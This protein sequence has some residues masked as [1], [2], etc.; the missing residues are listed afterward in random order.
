M[1]DEF[2]PAAAR[3]LLEQSSGEWCPPDVFATFENFDANLAGIPVLAY[4]YDAETR[5]AGA[6]L[7]TDDR[8]TMEHA[9]NALQS[10]ANR[11]DVDCASGLLEKISVRIHPPDTHKK[12]D[13]SA[14]VF[15]RAHRCGFVIAE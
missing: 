9:S 5:A 11:R 6:A 8:A 3:S 2:G 10:G 1:T 4:P 15:A 13:G 14:M 12:R 7:D